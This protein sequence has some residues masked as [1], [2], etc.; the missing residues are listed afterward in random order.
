MSTVRASRTGV[1]DTCGPDAR[2]GRGAFPPAV[3]RASRTAV[4]HAPGRVLRNASQGAVRCP[5]T[6][7]ATRSTISSGSAEASGSAL[8]T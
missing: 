6:T 3:E 2:G 4:E 5:C 1:P 7:G 8:I